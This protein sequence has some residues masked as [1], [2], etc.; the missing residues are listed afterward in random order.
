VPSAIFQRLQKLEKLGVLL[1][2]EARIDPQAIGL[3]LTAFRVRDTGELGRLLRERVGVIEAVRS[4]ESRRSSSSS[5][6]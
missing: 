3:G 1:G 4:S 5:A 2:H 6:C